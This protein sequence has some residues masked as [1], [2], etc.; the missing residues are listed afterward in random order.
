MMELSE[1]PSLYRAL[2]ELRVPLDEKQ[3]AMDVASGLLFLHNL[4]PVV[5]HRDIKSPNVLL[6]AR[7]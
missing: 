6:S 4:K 5:V 7:L 3:I 1:G 2:Y